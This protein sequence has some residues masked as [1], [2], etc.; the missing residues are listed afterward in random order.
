MYAYR[1]GNES[2]NLSNFEDDGELGGGREIMAVV[3]ERQCFNHLVAVTRW[4]G[5]HHMGPSRFEHIKKA[6]HNAISLA[7]ETKNETENA[8]DTRETPGT[9]T[10][11]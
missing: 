1:I 2:Y 4:Y 11:E 7:K 6:A 10:H 9:K 5:G 3:D 8:M